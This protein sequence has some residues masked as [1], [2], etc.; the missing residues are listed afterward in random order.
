MSCRIFS[1]SGRHSEEFS[2]N[3]SDGEYRNSED[4]Q[5]DPEKTEDIHW[6]TVH[7]AA[8]EHDSDHDLPEPPH[9]LRNLP[10]KVMTPDGEPRYPSKDANE[11]DVSRPHPLDGRSFEQK[12]RD[13]RAVY[14]RSTVLRGDLPDGP[15]LLTQALRCVVS[16]DLL[17]V[18]IDRLLR[19][20]RA[21]YGRFI[22][23]GVRGIGVVFRYA[24]L[25]SWLSPP[26]TVTVRM[27]QE[28]VRVRA[29]RRE[30]IRVRMM[31]YVL[32]ARHF[33]HELRNVDSTL[34]D[35]SSMIFIYYEQYAAV[36]AQA[37]ANPEQRPIVPVPTPPAE[38]RFEADGLDVASAEADEADHMK[39]A[40]RRFFF[41][42]RGMNA[43]LEDIAA[44]QSVVPDEAKRLQAQAVRDCHYLLQHPVL[45]VRR[46]ALSAY[47]NA[48]F[49]NYTEAH[50]C[51]IVLNRFAEDA[52][53]LRRK[54][55]MRRNVGNLAA[56]RS[57]YLRALDVLRMAMQEYEDKRAELGR[58]SV[59]SKP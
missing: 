11:L 32:M 54:Y 46:A 7:D 45:Q 5:E 52:N 51:M 17:K 16:A 42:S 36:L 23:S 29:T 59:A 6:P 4:E 33:A 47:K 50:C 26:D 35:V 49:F 41:H 22:F 15:T 30:Q 43:D 13:L 25:M 40:D 14:A 48:K 38:T 10:R 53:L 8:R 44:M 9:F 21:L 28:P 20:G 12:E 2:G 58:V 31:M 37:K 55:L 3:E 27:R 39:F 34:G 18:D 24:R 1:M 19:F 57:H 56:L